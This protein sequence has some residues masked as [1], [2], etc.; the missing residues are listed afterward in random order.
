M[1][2][3]VYGAGAIGGL[4][5]ARL[6]AAGEAVTVVARGDTL[7]SLQQHGAGLSENDETQFYPVTAVAAPPAPT[8]S[9]TPTPPR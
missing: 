7:Q 2:V 8:R 5:A 3:C 9:R 1:N 4:I 6:S